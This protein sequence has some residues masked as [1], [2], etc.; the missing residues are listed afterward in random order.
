MKTTLLIILI[1]FTS[2]PIFAD[3][4]G[5][6][7]WALPR[8]G[9]IKQNSKFVL[10]GYFRSQR[11][12]TSLNKKY[13]IYLESDQHKVKLIVK[14]TYKG[15]FELTQ[16]ILYP[17]E[18]LIAGKT[19]VLKIDNLDQFENSLLFRRNA[20]IDQKE[21]IAWTIEEGTDNQN[22]LFL[23]P[24]ELVDKRTIHY[25]CGPE[26]YADFKIKVTDESE[27]LFQTEFVDIKSGNS[28]IYVLN[29]DD[30]ET[31]SVGHGMCAGAFEY[32]ENGQ[33]KVRFLLMDICGNNNN[34]WTS[35]IKFD[36]PYV[37]N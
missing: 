28:T 1:T 2:L 16:A 4:D 13:P 19:Y 5:D 31:L 23:S 18:K 25:G 33:Y 36:S 22:P 37:G 30:T 15:M 8:S 24:P 17:E 14:N 27:L 34:E 6:G 9:S 12:V 10:T 11:I 21:P 32:K 20:K 35:W 7:L 29:L 3:C 26:V